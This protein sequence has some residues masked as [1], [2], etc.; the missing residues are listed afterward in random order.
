MR[1]PLEDGVWPVVSCG[2]RRAARTR[3]TQT[4]PSVASPHGVHLAV[5]TE[6]HADGPTTWWTLLLPPNPTTS[7]DAPDRRIRDR[8]RHLDL[9]SEF[10]AEGRPYATLAADGRVEI[11]HPEA[12]ER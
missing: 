8:I 5:H 3:Q 7:R 1:Y 11:H 9:A 10:E 12:L 6:N 2:T 4:G